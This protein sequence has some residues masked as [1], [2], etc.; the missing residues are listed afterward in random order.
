MMKTQSRPVTSADLENLALAIA[1]AHFQADRAECPA[2]EALTA[3]APVGYLTGV[4]SI[5]RD[6]RDEWIDE[7]TDTVRAAIARADDVRQR[8]VR[9]YAAMRDQ[10]YGAQV[11]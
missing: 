9:A 3:D 2:G 6:I 5:E 4:C 11:G 7:P 1:S 8:V 10:W